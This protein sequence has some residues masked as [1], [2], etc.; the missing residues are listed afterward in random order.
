MACFYSLV[1]VLICCAVYFVNIDAVMIKEVCYGWGRG[2]AMKI[3][4]VSGRTFTNGG[5]KIIVAKLC[6]DYPITIT[7]I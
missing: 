1:G 3:S 5:N 6:K 2:L 7:H 4:L